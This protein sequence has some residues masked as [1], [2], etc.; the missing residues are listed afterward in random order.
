MNIEELDE[1]CYRNKEKIDK[2]SK[3]FSTIII[4]TICAIMHTIGFTLPV[5]L[6]LICSFII[7]TCVAL[8]S[9]PDLDSIFSRFPAILSYFA[10]PVVVLAVYLKTSLLDEGILSASFIYIAIVIALLTWTLSFLIHCFVIKTLDVTIFRNPKYKYTARINHIEYNKSSYSYYVHFYDYTNFKNKAEIKEK[11]AL[12]W[13]PRDAIEITLQPRVD[14][15]KIC[16][17]NKMGSFEGK[18]DMEILREE[19]AE[20]VKLFGQSQLE[21]AEEKGSEKDINFMIKDRLRDEKNFSL[22]AWC[23]AVFPIFL[24]MAI[25]LIGYNFKVICSP[26]IF[27]IIFICGILTAA[28]VSIFEY[29]KGS[30]THSIEDIELWKDYLY[31]R[32]LVYFISST[33][34]IGTILTL[35]NNYAVSPT[36]FF[37]E[38]CYI[39]EKK[40]RRNGRSTS[41]HIDYTRPNGENRSMKVN[42][43]QFH[44]IRDSVIVV[45]TQGALGAVSEKYCMLPE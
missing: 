24:L 33:L 31:P 12:F 27:G 7:G 13:N 21:L 6:G 14:T 45:F 23:I 5:I 36:S 15:I 30:K 35:I 20:K 17:V 34:L 26:I 2:Y 9:R 44:D 1:I 4:V 40:C 41:Y 43:E 39:K 37:Q 32:C 16:S 42:R 3:I 18:T 11:E 25:Y 19:H 29:Y 22:I 38:K 8:I 10:T 28:I